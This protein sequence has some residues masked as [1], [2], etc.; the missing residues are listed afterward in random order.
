MNQ[1][2]TQEILDKIVGRVFGFKN[3]FTLEQFMQRYAFDV[4]LPSQVNDSTTSEE[5]WAQSVNPTKFITMDNAAKGI[6]GK[7]DW[8]M[9]KKPLSSI[10]DILGAWNEVN[11]TTTERHVDSLGVSECDNIYNSENVYRSQDVH[12][13]K[14]ILFCDGIMMNG[15]FLAACQRSNSSSFSI[16]LEDSKDC[17]NSFSVSWS[18]KISNSMFI[19]DCFDLFECLFCSHIAS[20]KFCIANIQFEEAEYRKLKDII[21]RWILTN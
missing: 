15:E 2:Q 20:K 3:P 19:H 6:E 5:T 8:L 9:P 14:N 21:V 18:G 13:S 16:R 1:A 7:S 4:K 11:Y 12:A 17:S 10:E